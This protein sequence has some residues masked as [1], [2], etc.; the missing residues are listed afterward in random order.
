[1]RLTRRQKNDSGR[2]ITIPTGQILREICVRWEDKVDGVRKT[3]RGDPE[4]TYAK[5]EL[6][7]AER[8]HRKGRSPHAARTRCF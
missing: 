6:E 5:S 4:P 7:M 3:G 2:T 8:Q 1:M